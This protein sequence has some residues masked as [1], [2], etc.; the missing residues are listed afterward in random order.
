MSIEVTT[1]SRSSLGSPPYVRRR[2][3]T[4]NLK[5]EGK[6]GVSKITCLVKEKDKRKPTTVE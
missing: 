1:K 6:E 3:T 4:P 5:R 2:K